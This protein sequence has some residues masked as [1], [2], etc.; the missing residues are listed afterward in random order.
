MPFKL[1]AVFAKEGDSLL[2]Y[3]GSDDEPQILLIDGGSRGVYRGWL[4]PRLQELRAALG[5]ERVPL[6]MVMISHVDGDHITGILDLFEELQESDDPVC[7]VGTLWHNSFDDLVG[8]EAG[9]LATA[10][11]QSLADGNVPDSADWDNTAVAASIGQ[12]RRLRQ[13]AEALGISTND[14]FTGLVIATPDTVAP[15]AIGGGMT[16]RVLGP[17]LARVEALQS[18]WNKH[19]EEKGLAEAVAAGLEDNSI[20]NLSSLMVLAEQDGKT[21]LLTGDARGDYIVEG[22]ILAGLLPAEA[23][24]PI[25]FTGIPRSE[26]RE[27]KEQLVI[28]EASENPPSVHFDLLKLPHHGS[29]R[30]VSTGF[31][32]RVTADRYLC[33]AD[34]NHHNPDVPTLRMLAEARGSAPYTLYFTFTADQHLDETA[35]ASFRE[36]LAAVDHWVRSEKPANCTV[37]HRARREALSVE[38]D[39]SDPA[40]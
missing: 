6:Q 36:A 17:S 38:V 9:E 5:G 40:T 7:D 21:M 4:R 28:A 1:E 25:L 11:A 34:G 23:E 30:N 22:L 13:D 37:V 10:I 33:S 19:L 20:P 14:P 39:L 29:D 8:N 32:R 35:N 15:I 2:L 31:F 26:R 3:Y 24:L 12:G 16:F 18:S 27:K